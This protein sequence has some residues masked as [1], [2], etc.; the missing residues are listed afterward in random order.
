MICR[1]LRNLVTNASEKMLLWKIKSILYL[2]KIHS[3]HFFLQRNQERNN[4]KQLGLD[5]NLFN[6]QA[7]FSLRILKGLLKDNNIRLI[8]EED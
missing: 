5:K 2:G 4:R 3:S 6:G 7:R 1:L 8:I